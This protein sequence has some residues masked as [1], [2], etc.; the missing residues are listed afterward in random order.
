MNALIERLRLLEA[1]ILSSETQRRI[2]IAA[3]IAVLSAMKRRIFNDGLATDGSKIGT[4]STYSFYKNP[5]SLLGVPK[6]GVKP[7]GK[8]GLA[9]FKNGK[10]KKT[11]YLASGYKELRELVGRQ[12]DYV[13]LSFS[14][15]MQQSLQFGI[16][17]ND[18]V[19]GFTNQE[20]ADVMAQN[21]E[22][23]GLEIQETSESE[24]ELGINAARNELLFI[25]EQF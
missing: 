19:V 17:N 15:S 4:Y 2:S 18:A 1:A 23:F 8:N 11:K 5:N 22:R 9:I 10:Q 13:D 14:G 7:Q 3:S 20:S 16:R 21:E 25:I 12:S 6:G 24:S